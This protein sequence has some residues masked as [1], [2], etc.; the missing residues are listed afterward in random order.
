MTLT[1]IFNRIERSWS[2]LTN[3]G[4]ERQ[5]V[6]KIKTINKWVKKF[7]SRS[8]LASQ[9]IKRSMNVLAFHNAIGIMH[10]DYDQ[11]LLT[12]NYSDS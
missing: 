6:K 4:A 2:S 9:M 5:P 1:P 10:M 8:P 11:F 7:K 12:Q 3:F